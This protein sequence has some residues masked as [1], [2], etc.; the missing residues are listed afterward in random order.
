[1]VSMELN[2]SLHNHKEQYKNLY[3]RYVERMVNRP[4]KIDW[5]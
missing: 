5:Q 1:M 3:N 2:I 4:E